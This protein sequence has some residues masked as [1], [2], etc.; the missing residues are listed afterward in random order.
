MV[1]DHLRQFLKSGWKSRMVLNVSYVC[2][3]GFKGSLLKRSFC[4]DVAGLKGYQA[5]KF[6]RHC[7][8]LTQAKAE[9]AGR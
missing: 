7:G 9:D 3:S 4:F 2:I 5:F 8:S 6:T 1:E